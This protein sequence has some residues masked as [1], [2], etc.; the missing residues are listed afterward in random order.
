M[1]SGARSSRACAP[2]PKPESARGPLSNKTWAASIART[3][4]DRE[5][6]VETVEAISALAELLELNRLARRDGRLSQALDARREKLEKLAAEVVEAHPLPRGDLEAVVR[7]SATREALVPGAYTGVPRRLLRSRAGRLLLRLGAA[8]GVSSAGAVGPVFEVGLEGHLVSLLA[9]PLPI[10]FLLWGLIYPAALAW[11]ERRATERTVGLPPLEIILFTIGWI[12]MMAIL[13]LEGADLST[14]LASL[15]LHVSVGA[16]AVTVARPLAVSGLL[17]RVAA[18]AEAEGR[19]HLEELR[20]SE[21]RLCLEKALI[22]SPSS[23]ESSVSDADRAALLDALRVAILFEAEALR[24]A[25]RRIEARALLAARRVRPEDKASEAALD[26]WATQTGRPAAELAEQA[27]LTQR[28]ARLFRA[29]GRQKDAVRCYRRAARAARSSSERARAALGL[30]ELEQR[31]EGWLVRDLLEDVAVRGGAAR[32]TLSVL[33]ALPAEVL[34]SDLVLEDLGVRLDE[35][36]AERAVSVLEGIAGSRSP[37]DAPELFLL[38]AK[39]YRRLGNKGT[40]RR[41]EAEVGPRERGPRPPARAPSVAD[42]AALDTGDLED[43][44]ADRYALLARIGAGA[45]GEVHLAED[46][47]LGR[48]VALKVLRPQLASELLVEKFRDEARVVASLDHPGIVRVFDA[49]QTGP[50]AYFVMELIDGPDLHTVLSRSE[51]PPLADRVRWIAE[52]AEAMAY[53]HARGVIHRDLKPANVLIASDGRARVTDFGVAH[54]PS[55]KPDITG[56]S[57]AGLIV[58]TPTFMAPEQLGHGAPPSPMTDVYAAG[59]ML[60]FALTGRLPFED[61]LLERI[62]SPPPRVSAVVRGLSAEL[63]EVSAH[64]LE[65]SPEARLGSM[66]ALAARLRESPELAGEPARRASA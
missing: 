29:L 26:A 48:R 24:A 49:G 36:P 57:R 31:L 10:G 5:T 52:V 17:R 13:L 37:T 59:V 46:L 62:S 4:S 53:A 21:A 32:E 9:G 58:G 25:E 38:L 54:V 1:P 64:A 30:V 11:A 18:L 42:A 27:G 45:M 63:E 34:E 55:A 65:P 60:F 44:L 40:A 8:L 15:A 47:V 3:A 6:V 35:A 41:I 2:A 33:A 19:A 14:W 56:F 61:D 66:E 28:A 43:A 39:A 7:S 22:L 12:S 16:A 20:P 50:W 51:L 23:C